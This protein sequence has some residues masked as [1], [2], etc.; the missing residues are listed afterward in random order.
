VL[1]VALASVTLLLG[2]PE[3]ENDESDKPTEAFTI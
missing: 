2:E 1:D 3:I